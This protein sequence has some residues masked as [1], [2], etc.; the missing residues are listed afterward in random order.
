[1]K[2]KNKN[3]NCGCDINHKKSKCNCDETCTC[4]CQQGGPCLCEDECKCGCHTHECSCEDECECENGCECREG[5]GCDISSDALGYLEMAQR[6]QAD[7]E[8]YKKRNADVA[9]K[10]YNLG[11]SDFVEKLLPVMDSFKQARQTITDSQALS[12]LNLIHGQ[13]LKALSCFG[14]KKI[15]CV[16]KE[17]DPN[18][19]NA[20]LTESNPNVAD[21]VITEELQEGFRSETKIIRHSVVK[22]N[23]I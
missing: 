19:H 5:C 8:N 22:I 2:N 23:K 20:V 9:N 12:G 4:G 10:S 3:C 13:I 18:L 21:N 11:V 7:F 1:M 16:G 14:I 6:I 15:E 17:F